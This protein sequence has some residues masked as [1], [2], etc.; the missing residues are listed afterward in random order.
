MNM[1]HQSKK[2]HVGHYLKSQSNTSSISNHDRNSPELAETV[3]DQ[4]GIESLQKC[5][6]D[7]N[8]SLKRTTV[9]CINQLVKHNSEITR[10]VMGSSNDIVSQ[11]ADCILNEDDKSLKK[12][13]LLCLSNIAKHQRHLAEKVIEVLSIKNISLLLKREED[14]QIRINLLNLVET[15]CSHSNSFCKKIFNAELINKL[16][17]IMVFQNTSLSL[18]MSL[19]CLINVIAE[20]DSLLASIILNSEIIIVIL[21]NTLIFRK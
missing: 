18:E 21:I 12:Q 4:V 9:N 13:S 17:S 19:L 2:L 20:T 6:F 15:L 1:I 11:L 14:E 7:P 5:L 8:L 16:Y 10:K 3:I